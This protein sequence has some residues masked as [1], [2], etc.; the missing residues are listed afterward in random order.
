M[1][2]DRRTVIKDLGVAG[3]LGLAGTTQVGSCGASGDG[4]RRRSS[5]GGLERDL[6]VTQESG[7]SVHWVLPGKHEL[8]RAVSGTPENPQFRTSLL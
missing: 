2:L 7:K 1:V 3:G 8:E 4:D 5:D 6:T